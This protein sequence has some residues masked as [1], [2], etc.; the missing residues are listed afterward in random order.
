MDVQG[1]LIRWAVLLLHRCTGNSTDITFLQPWVSTAA[2]CQ[3]FQLTALKPLGVVSLLLYA[4]I[5]YA[6][7][8]RLLSGQNAPSWLLQRPKGSSV[9]VSTMALVGMLFVPKFISPYIPNNLGKE[10]NI[11]KVKLNCV[12]LQSLVHYTPNL[13]F[14]SL[15]QMNGGKIFFT[16][17]ERQELFDLQLGILMGK[18]KGNRALNL[19]TKIINWKGTPRHMTYLRSFQLLNNDNV[20]RLRNFSDRLNP[21]AAFVKAEMG[22]RNMILLCF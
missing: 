1:R 18:H 8:L 11:P 13:L 20:T 15:S 14:M 3:D 6:A 9:P 5:P 12:K 16:S 4:L 17:L 22:V 10:L 21:G 19:K 7:A 2:L